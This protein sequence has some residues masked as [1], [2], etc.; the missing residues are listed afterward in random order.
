MDPV[1]K[2]LPFLLL[3]FFA[4]S[5]FAAKAAGVEDARKMVDNIGSQ[6]LSTIESKGSK[7]QKQAKLEKLFTGNVDIAWVGRFVMGRYWKQA[8]AEQKS[9]YL[10]EYQSFI[11]K[12]Y[13]GR[14][15]D[16]TGGS[17]KVTNATDDGENQYTVTMQMKS[18]DGVEVLVDY[19]V[20]P[21]DGGGLKIFDVVVEGVS[22]IS[23]QRSEFASVLNNNGID[24]LIKQLESHAFEVPTGK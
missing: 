2:L 23:T 13:A 18:P 15:A 7:D 5:P 3:A 16:Y 24:Y 4:V 14:F 12:N 19:R 9:H 17:Y 6:A 1:R 21:A 20:H 8:T 11:V 10:R 22:L